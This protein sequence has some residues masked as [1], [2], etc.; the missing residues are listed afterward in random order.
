VS[1]NS[2]QNGH[3]QSTFSGNTAGGG[4]G[5]IG[6]FGASITITNSTFSGNT[7]LNNS[8][9]GISADILT[10]TNSTIAS[11]TSNTIGGGISSG[12]TTTL[13]NTIIANNQGSDCFGAITSQGYNLASDGTCNLTASTDLPTTEPMLGPL[14]D[15]GGPTFTQALLPGS[16][17]I[18]AGGDCPPPPTDQRGVSRPQGTACDIGAFEVEVE[19]NLKIL[20]FTATPTLGTAPI[21]GVPVAFAVTVDNPSLV[22]SQFLAQRRG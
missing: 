6:S 3:A 19:V 12:S 2:T 17:A 18:D 7:A 10:V 11:N 9:G 20:S 22:S 15:N 13:K 4:G 14:Q 5:G 16:P 8:G 21:V 1:R